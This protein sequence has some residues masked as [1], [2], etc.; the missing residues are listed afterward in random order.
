MTILRIDTALRRQQILDAADDVFSEH[1]VHAPLELV[2]ERAGLGQATLYRNFPDRIALMSALLERSLEAFACAARDLGDRPDGL[3]VLLHDIAEYIAESAPMLDFWRT[4]ERDHPAIEGAD[5]RALEILMP[6]VRRAIDAG[7]CR[8][9]VDEEQVLLVMDMLGGC[10]RGT[11]DGERRRL[12][13]RSADL[14]M[15]A[16]GLS[17]ESLASN[18]RGHA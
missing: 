8:P 16:L 2:V 17:P 6:F 5:G 15:R 3:G 4:M 10:M 7:L 12:A 18:P 11:D 9:D 1:G 14:L 13:H